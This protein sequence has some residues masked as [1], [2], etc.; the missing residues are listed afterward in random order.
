MRDWPGGGLGDVTE[1]EA[2]KHD[3]DNIAAPGDRKAVLRRYRWEVVRPAM[4]EYDRSAYNAAAE[5]V[6]PGLGTSWRTL[7]PTLRAPT[8]S[9]LMAESAHSLHYRLWAVCRLTG[10]WPLQVLGGGEA[11]ELPDRCQACGSVDV[12]LLH[13]FG[14]CPGT[15]GLRGELRSGMGVPHVATAHPTVDALFGQG[16]TVEDIRFV[17]RAVL[18]CA[19]GL[20]GGA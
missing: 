18:A 17:G 11:P 13:A 8:S 3:I 4:L 7:H 10:R 15:T 16:H 19:Q 1:V 20:T 5:R 6:I 9:E 12:P 2:L 14:A